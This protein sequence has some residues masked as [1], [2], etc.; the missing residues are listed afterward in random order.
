[1]SSRARCSTACHASRPSSISGLSTGSVTAWRRSGS[2]PSSPSS[3]AVRSSSARSPVRS[4]IDAC[5][6]RGRT[7]PHCRWPDTNRHPPSMSVSTELGELRTVDLPAG[8]VAY[9]ERGAGPPVVFVHGVGVNGDLW[10]NVAPALA[11]GH[12]CIVPDL[13]FGAHAH[14]LRADADLS[15]P[16]LAKIVADLL[17]ALDLRDGAIVANDTGGAVAQWLVGHQAE[18]VGRLVL[19]SCDAL[20]KFPPAP[21]RYLEV[22][23]R[24]RALMWLVAWTAQFK[25]VQRL[26]TAYGWVT[27]RPIDPAIMRSFTD[28]VRTIP[29]VRRDLQRLLRAVSTRYTHDAAGA[30]P[31]FDRPALAL[32]ADGDRI[33]PREHGRLL[34]QLLPQ[35]RFELVAD[36]RTFIPEDQP[37]ALVERTRAFLAH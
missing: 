7:T 31:S 18:R 11:A 33:F 36:S 23:A 35:G 3:A 14:P 22:A 2:W 28:P 37:A 5:A 30:L 34:A 27:R 32:W 6:P 20:H 8:T 12:R 10:R 17:A 16:G 19:T 21:Q 25:A 9:R 15:L 29:G 4:A 24:S 13:P 1:M 26:P